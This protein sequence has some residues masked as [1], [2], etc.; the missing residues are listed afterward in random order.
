MKERLALFNP[1]EH[2]NALKTFI[3]YIATTLKYRMLK[4]ITILEKRFQ[5]WCHA[6]GPY[7]ILADPI[8]AERA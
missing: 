1:I 4:S 6:K 8:R 5:T 7:V 3:D 2:Q